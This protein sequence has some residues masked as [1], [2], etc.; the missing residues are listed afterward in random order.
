VHGSGGD[1]SA[2]P[3]SALKQG[4]AAFGCHCL[5]SLL[6]CHYFLPMQAH[7]CPSPSNSPARQTLRSQAWGGGSEWLRAGGSGGLGTFGDILR[8]ASAA[9]CYGKLFSRWFSCVVRSCQARLSVR[10]THSVLAAQAKA[11]SSFR[12]NAL[13]LAGTGACRHQ[14]KPLAITQ[15]CVQRVPQHLYAC[16][17]YARDDFSRR[18]AC[19]THYF[20]LPLLLHCVCAVSTS[21]LLHAFSRLQQGAENFGDTFSCLSA[22]RL[23]C[24][25]AFQPFGADSAR[26]LKRR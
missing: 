23:G 6:A 3:I 22:E 25:A 17:K 11:Y 8:R 1:S 7:H 26:R 5:F 21:L 12:I 9:F 10:R 14:L 24:L 13:L 20:P 2:F 4:V 19:T 15:R 16:K 18:N